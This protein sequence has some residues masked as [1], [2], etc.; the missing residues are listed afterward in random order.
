MEKV[1]KNNLLIL[2]KVVF[3]S[4][5]VLTEAKFSSLMELVRWGSRTLFGTKDVPLSPILSR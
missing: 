1:V 5:L 4:I 3:L 2:E